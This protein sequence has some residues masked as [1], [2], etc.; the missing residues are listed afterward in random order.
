MLFSKDKS[1]SMQDLLLE[2]DRLT[3]RDDNLTAVDVLEANK[4][5]R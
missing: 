3:M 2:H 1:R 5:L 4:I